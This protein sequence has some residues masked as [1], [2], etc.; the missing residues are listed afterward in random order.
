[1]SN[2]FPAGVGL[3][4]RFSHTNA[5]LSEQPDTPWFELIAD[6]LLLHGGRRQVVDKLRARYPLALHAVGL[7]IAGVDPL[8]TEYL[9]MLAELSQNYQ[10][11]W[12]S[13]HLCWC[14]HGGRQ[15]FDLYPVP[16][17][18]AA[19]DHISSRV[20]QVQDLLRQ[21]LVLENISYY[22]RFISD[23]MSEW[24]F[25]VELMRRTGCR[26][27]L[28]LNNLWTNAANFNRCPNADLNALLTQLKPEQIAQIHLAGASY[29]PPASDDD[30][31]Y[32]ID[33][34]GEAVPEPVIEL[35]RQTW[36]GCPE[37]P[38]CI[39]RDTNLPPFAT[40]EAERQALLNAVITQ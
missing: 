28:D 5:V 1:M 8:D 22:H 6:D 18:S 12:L 9:G 31:C 38:V 3:G 20:Q 24:D 25:T 14:A 13:D 10:A 15:H 34:H 35:L 7:N 2:G 29:Q 4:F 32:W 27:L 30:Q 11:A 33:T 17:S 39:E 26:L 40:L 36:A 16:F 37:V 21:P 19:L 23:E